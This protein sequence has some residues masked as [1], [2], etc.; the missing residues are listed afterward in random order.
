MQ[1]E[2][3]TDLDLELRSMLQDAEEEVPSRVWSALSAELDRRD[4]RKV[5]ALRW[6]RAGVAVAAAAAVCG[7]VFFGLNIF[8]GTDVPADGAIVAQVGQHSDAAAAEPED[9]PAIEEQIAASS[10]LFMA[11]VPQKPSTSSRSV[12]VPSE[13]IPSDEA[14]I[15]ATET[16]TPAENAAPAENAVAEEASKPSSQT[17]KAGSIKEEQSWDDPFA[18]MEDERHD[19]GRT[20]F[21]ISGNA[22]SNDMSDVSHKPLRAS[23]PGSLG[24]GIQEKSVSTYGIPLSFGLGVRF[25]LSDK[26]S[27]GTGIDWTLLSRSFTGIYTNGARSVNSEINNEIHYIGLP[28]NLYFDILSDGDIKFYVWGGGSVEKGLVNRFRIQNSPDDIIFK[29]S[30]KGLQWSSA[31]GLGIEFSLNDRL[32]LYLDP[33]ARYY[34]DCGQ[35]NSV[36]TA[37]PFMLNFEAGLRFDL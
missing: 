17:G 5:V 28:L 31:V 20:S 24:T 12:T 32:G 30:V 14:V 26:L 21:F 6:R 7:A 8:N 10:D 11:D 3:Y 4:R 29:Q 23:G 22:T 18:T 15:P 37:K 1:N 13:I 34:F 27:L 19:A 2:K 9:I 35:P 33:S 16:A 25:S 36:R